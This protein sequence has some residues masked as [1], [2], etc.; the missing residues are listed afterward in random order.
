MKAIQMTLGEDLV[1]VVDCAGA[2]S[3]ALGLGR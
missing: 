3:F 2:I 1:A